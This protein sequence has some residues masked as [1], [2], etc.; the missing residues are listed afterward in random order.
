MGG[1]VGDPKLKPQFMPS[2]GAFMLC[3]ET[4]KWYP[5]KKMSSKRALSTSIA[6]FHDGKVYAIGGETN[7][8]C[9]YFDLQSREWKEMPSYSSYESGDLHMYCMSTY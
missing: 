1:I 8:S 4:L 7:A 3:M 6:P 9:E 5:L 2:S